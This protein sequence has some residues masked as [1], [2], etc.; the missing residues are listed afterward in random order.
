MMF[1]E[2]P[3]RE[4]VE[5]RQAEIVLAAAEA[6]EATLS[7][8][9]ALVAERRRIDLTGL[10]DEIGRLCAAALAAPRAAAPALRVRFEAM[11]RSLDRLRAGLGP[12]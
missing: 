5:A 10:E 4:A 8:A 1:G 2:P 11:V 7:V 3:S 12:P 9:E 6:M